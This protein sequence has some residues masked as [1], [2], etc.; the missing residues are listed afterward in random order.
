MSPAAFWFQSPSSWPAVLVLLAAC[1][2]MGLTALF[3]VQLRR[4]VCAAW[5]ETGRIH[6][7]STARI[8]AVGDLLDDILFETDRS[9]T[10]VFTNH[11]F[12][13]LTGYRDRDLHG[14]LTLADLFEPDER[15]RL[16][17]ELAPDRRR[18]GPTEGTYHLRCRDGSRVPVALRL[19]PITERDELQGWRGLLE[20]IAEPDAAHD[21]P[22]AGA[23]ER[24]LGDIL[25]DFKQAPPHEHEAA[26]LRGL[27]AIGG[28]LG[29]DRCYFY[30]CSEDGASLDSRL[31]WYGPDV[32]PLEDDARL[33]GLDEFPWTRDRFATDGVVI[34][35]DLAALDP[36]EVPERSRWRQQGITSLIGVALR[37]RGAVTG[38][39]GCETLGRVRPWN[40]RDRHL[41]E[42]LAEIC[43]QALHHDR[44]ERHLEQ[45]NARTADLAA[46]LPEPVAVTD[47]TGTVVVWNTALATLSGLPAAA[48][49]GRPVAE[50]LD[51]FLPAVRPWLEARFP[52]RAED[53]AVCSEIQET[54]S[55]AGEPVWVQLSLRA[56]APAA[57]ERT[58]CLLHFCDLTAAK[59]A[60]ARVRARN[61]KLEQAVADQQ[62]ELAQAQAKLLESEKMAAVARMVTGLAHEINTPVGVGLTAASHLGDRAATLDRTY[63]DGLMTRSDFEDF[64]GS[65]GESATLIQDNLQRAADLI[66][67]MRQA[68]M[69]QA[70]DRVRP[71][72]LR[73]YLGDVLLSLGPRLREQHAEVRLNCP[74]QL[75]LVTDPGALYRILSNLVINSLQHGFESMLVGNIE[76]TVAAHPRGVQL[77]YQDDGRGMDADERERMFEPFYT[78]ARGRGGMGLGL[79]IVYSLVTGKLGGSIACTS[80]PGHGVRFELII[81]GQAEAEAS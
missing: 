26:L 33:P 21:A 61:Q 70:L 17:A 55:G 71:V 24:V 48:V 76:I 77:V 49:Q 1:S 4:Q 27:A 69:D 66:S 68:A 54:L 36:H 46:L 44:T 79:H 9:R 75:S 20:S 78:T 62:Q 39:L 25:R 30:T 53:D 6:A 15:A 63:R 19:S 65:A 60:E 64:L 43:Q 72:P 42:T 57:G 47:A 5:T 22:P 28:H 14:G 38:V 32:S 50:A 80:R 74:E 51:G 67:G 23:V 35:H 2:L 41:L 58:G 73:E 81:P 52:C 3:M 16:L 12:H 59:A 56:L 13:R 18:P 29:V 11:A 31:Q 45:A 10:L 8:D 40:P 34:V 37:E 7:R